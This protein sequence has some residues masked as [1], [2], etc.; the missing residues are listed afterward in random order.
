MR[1][2][3]LSVIALT[4]FLYSSCHK[5]S[6]VLNIQEEGI[7]GISLKIDKA[8]APSN[9]V[10][11]TALLTREGYESLSGEMNLLTETSAEIYFEEIYAGK[12]HLLVEALNETGTVVYRGETDI[13]IL[14]GV[15]TEV[16]LVLSPT[17][18]GTGDIY[19]YVTWGSSE[20]T[21][22][23]NNPIV[24][25]D[26]TTYDRYG[27]GVSFV[28]KD[29]MNYKMWYTGL[30][31]SGISYVYYA[32]SEDGLSWTKYSEIPVLFPDSLGTWDYYHVSSGPVI[33][34]D[35]LYKMY[36]SGWNDQHGAWP[37]GLATSE[38]G[39]NWIRYD[40]NPILTGEG[41]DIQIRAQSIIK[42][43]GLY[44]MFFTGGTGNNCR[45]GV[46]TSPDGYN[47]EKYAGNPVLINEYPWE[48]NAVAFPSVIL[49]D[50]QFVMIYQGIL[51]ANTA[52][53]YAYSTDGF[54]WTK[55][56][57]NPFFKTEDANQPCYK[58]SFPHYLKT[59]K[60]LRIYYTGFDAYTSDWY[61]C[62]ARKQN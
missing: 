20:W 7:G 24:L 29:D 33:K 36:Y 53:G 32:Y 38:D 60:E 2:Y 44:Y 42:K 13:T 51:D 46:A 28:L 61:I 62:L 19:I 23:I 10:K 41:W 21:D 16:N 5:D 47:W 58:I 9:V 8:N 56:N 48:G 31:H 45:I 26:N 17:G 59:D 12:W 40:H 27:V 6:S 1:F 49:E 37:V 57:K 52:F 14:E 25:K 43:N 50:N 30:S 4:F 39:I 18:E 3:I 34:E 54:H 11:V 55:G 22:Y 15:T 35:G